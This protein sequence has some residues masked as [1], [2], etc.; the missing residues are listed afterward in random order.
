M[1]LS[2]PIVYQ[3]FA[4]QPHPFYYIGHIV[5]VATNYSNL[6]YQ[7]FTNHYQSDPVLYI[8]SLPMITN[9]LPIHYYQSIALVISSPLV[10]NVLPII[11]L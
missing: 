3:S 1:L 9:K 8:T 7:C 6:M 5:A 10:V 2:L 11:N 4:N